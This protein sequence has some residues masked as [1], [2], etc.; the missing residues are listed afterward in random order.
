M[1]RPPPSERPVGHRYGDEAIL[2]EVPT[3]AGAVRVHRALLGRP[4]VRECI[5]AARTVLIEFD[6]RRLDAATVLAL[7]EAAH[8][9][10]DPPDDPAAD[11]P[12]VVLDVVYDGAD[13][14]ST[15]AELR[16]TTGQLVRRHAAAEYVVGFCGFI[17]GFAY[18][19]GLDPALHVPRLPSPR[20]SVPV[21][22]VA[23][24]GEFSG[25]YPRSTPG[26]WRLLGRTDATLWDLH[27]DPPAVLV[28]GTRVRFRAV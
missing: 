14:A 24:A 19:T 27:R 6:A 7:A 4:G 1:N 11:E 25:V 21:G 5:P 13:L 3:T 16:L 20:T 18:L 12:A 22:S 23:I 28:P 8:D 26:G 2:V 17:P 15:A 9:R 10:G